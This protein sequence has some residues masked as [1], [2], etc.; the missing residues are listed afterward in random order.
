MFVARFDIRSDAARFVFQPNLNKFWGISE[1]DTD[2]YTVLVQRE[3]NRVSFYYKSPQIE[4]RSTLVEWMKKIAALKKLDNS[5]IHLA[6]YLLDV[7]MDNH[8]IV[9]ERLYLV[10]LVCLLLASTSQNY[11]DK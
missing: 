10:A 3:K 5:S 1:Y 2:H 8:H 7:F 4:H 11:I 9:I 6:V